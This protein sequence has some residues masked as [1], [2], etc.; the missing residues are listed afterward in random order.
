MNLKSIRGN[1]STVIG[2]GLV[3]TAA[4]Y[5]SSL[6]LTAKKAVSK[7]DALGEAHEAAADKLYVLMNKQWIDVPAGPGDNSSDNPARP[8]NWTIEDISVRLKKIS[9][10]SPVI[11]GGT[12][13]S[14][15]ITNETPTVVGYKYDDF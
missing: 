14:R 12:G 13:A 11:K 6:M 10:S 7:G 2:I 4:L 5:F 15:Q 9:V 8:L 3:G 1:V